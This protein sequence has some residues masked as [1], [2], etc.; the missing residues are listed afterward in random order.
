MALSSKKLLAIDWD[1]RSLRLVLVRPRADGVD[2][3]KA[4][5]VPI[6][7][8]VV[9]DDAESLGAV[10]RQTIHRTK[11]GAKRAVLSIPRDQVVLNTLNLPAGPANDLPAIVQFQ[12]AKELPFAADQA[13]LDFAIV[14]A[15]DA[16]QPSTALVAAVRNEQLGFFQRVADEAGLSVEQ[17]GLRPHANLIAV[18]AKAPDLARKS[19]LLVEVG[20]QLTEIDIVRDGALAFSRAASV[21]LPDFERERRERLQDSRIE[22]TPV[23][24][25]EP[26][27]SSRKA[28]AGLMV[29]VIR[30][31]E[32]HRATDP[33]AHVDAVVVCGATGIEPE[34]AEALAARFGVKAEPFAPDRA[35]GL[36]SHRAKELRGFSAAIGLAIG[37]ADLGLSSFDFLHPKKPVSRRSIRLRKVP[38]AAL[39]AAFVLAAGYAAHHRHIAPLKERAAELVKELNEKKKVENVVLDFKAKVDAVEDWRKSEQYWPEVLVTL[40]EVLPS[41]Q[42][43][44]VTR[45]DFETRRPAKKATIRPSGMRMALRTAALGKVNVIAAGAKER[46]F[47]DVKPG[48]DIWTES[49]NPAEAVYHYETNIEA[50]LPLRSP[51]KAAAE[52]EETEEKDETVP[53]AEDLGVPKTDLPEAKEARPAEVTPDEQGAEAATPPPEPSAP[54]SDGES[55]EAGAPEEPI[56]QPSPEETPGNDIA[57]PNRPAPAEPAAGGSKIGGVNAGPPDSGAASLAGQPA[58]LGKPNEATNGA[59]GA[60]NRPSPGRPPERTVPGQAGPTTR[61][62]MHPGSRAGMSDG[63]PGLRTPGAPGRAQII[64]PPTTTQPADERGSPASGGLGGKTPSE[65]GAP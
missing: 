13:T 5:S 7:P 4:V 44:L 32:A 19:V 11:V 6:P 39:T 25:H 65:G 8:E 2:L 46:G 15:F 24:E 20:P 34:L 57:P 10:L 53:P 47:I 16:R 63:K 28:V 41:D 22:S 64:K 33:D 18:L 45:L 36:A 49:R 29:E 17:I 52:A 60:T 3:L 43:V 31:Y 51:P 12:I 1:R 42:E 62:A 61:P 26:D 56:D 55:G 21:T 9:M 58:P 30:S 50:E 37:H 35:L 38:T 27:E 59:P 14:G 48:K 54:P 40:T 23:S